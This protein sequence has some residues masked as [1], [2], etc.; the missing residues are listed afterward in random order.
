VTQ[1]ETSLPLRP[2]VLVQR[3]HHANL[4]VVSFDFFDTLV[5][6]TVP[7]PKD[8]FVAAAERLPP[9]VL[10]DALEP[11]AFREV[12]W[13]AEQRLAAQRSSGGPFSLTLEEVYS[14]ICDGAAWLWTPD[15]LAEHEVE[16]DAE[17]QIAN[18]WAVDAIRALR[19]EGFRV[20]VVSNTP[21]SSKDLLTFLR[22]LGWPGAAMPDR[23]Y[24][25][26]EHGASKQNGLFEVVLRDERI[27]AQE[28]AHIGDNPG[29]DGRATRRAGVQPWLLNLGTSYG[30]RFAAAQR[31]EREMLAQTPVPYEVPAGLIDVARMHAIADLESA[32]APNSRHARFGAFC[33]GPVL[34]PFVDWVIEQREDDERLVFLEREGVFLRDC[35][36]ALGAL[37]EDDGLVFPCSRLSLFRTVV[38]RLEEEEIV[39]FIRRMSRAGWE[40]VRSVLH[41]EVEDM[42]EAFAV[43]LELVP[44]SEDNI[45][46]VVRH[47]RGDQRLWERVRRT[48]ERLRDDLRE[49]L[50]V[51]EG[52]RLALVDLGYKATIQRFLSLALGERVRVRGFYLATLPDAFFGLSPRDV[53]GYVTDFGSRPALGALVRRNVALLEQC[54]MP[55]L[56][57]VTRVE[58]KRVRRAPLVI[59]QAQSGQQHDVQRGALAYAAC[60]AELSARLDTNRSLIRAMALIVLERSLRISQL[61][62]DLFAEWVHEVNLGHQ[63]TVPVLPGVSGSPLLSRVLSG[64]QQSVV[65]RTLRSTRPGRKL[66]KLLREPERFWADSRPRAW[67][68]QLSPRGART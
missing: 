13:R 44:L 16:S 33:V 68:R 14:E 61:E 1:S 25:S 30:P 15:Q 27:A 56:G 32:P 12:R 55:E 53:R 23:V 67:M 22:R 6:R 51:R 63:A 40:P 17:L 2:E 65:E 47:V 19:R 28:M 8:V 52:A 58:N 59:P 43:R 34:A 50:G 46:L 66:L 10:P 36:R 21:Y 39:S 60:Y 29:T 5:F 54:I 48:S 3:C 62:R 11:P 49:M 18:R 45:R 35:A 38:D 37:P 4:K 42:E 7:S 9:G 64:R 31:K 24:A 41:L 57:S 26:S 20:I